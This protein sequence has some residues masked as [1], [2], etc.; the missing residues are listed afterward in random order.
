MGEPKGFEVGLASEVWGHGGCFEGGLAWLMR[1]DLAAKG[2]FI[3]LAAVGGGEDPAAGCEAF[4]GEGEEFAVVFFDAKDFAVFV[5]GE[6][7]RVEDDAVEGAALFGEAFQ[8]MEGVAFAEVMVFWA[9][10]V[11]AEV[12]LGPVEV[13]L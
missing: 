9:E 8:P 11:E 4:Q 6:G 13:G 12:V 3:Q 7:G 2:L 10:L 5:A 1:G